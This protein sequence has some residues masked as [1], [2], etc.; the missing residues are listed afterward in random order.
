MPK[1]TRHAITILF[2]KISIHGCLLITLVLTLIFTADRNHQMTLLK[3]DETHLIKLVT[4]EYRLNFDIVC[5]DLIFLS[6]VVMYHYHTSGFD[7]RALNH[8]FIRLSASKKIY[9]SILLLNYKGAELSRVD[10]NDGN[11][12]IISKDHL[13]SM[14]DRPFFK[15]SIG[16]AMGDVSISSFQ[17]RRTDGRITEP[18][19][20]YLRFAT[21][22]FDRQGNR[23]GVIVLDYLV[24][25]LL[26]K[27]DQWGQDSAGRLMLINREGYYLKG[28]QPEHEWGFIFPKRSAH[29]IKNH[30]PMAWRQISASESGQFRTTNGLFSF[31]EILLLPDKIRSQRLSSVSIPS[32]SAVENGPWKLVS[33]VSNQDLTA[34]AMAILNHYF[35]IGF[36]LT[37]FWTTGA[38]WVAKAI[39]GGRSALGALKEN[40]MA[41][42][43][44]F[45]N[46]PNAYFSVRERDGRIIKHN[47]AAEKML[48]F[49]GEQL[50]GMRFTDLY[51]DTS[52]NLQPLR[53]IFNPEDQQRHYDNIEIQLICINGQ[54]KWA[55][56][57]IKPI[58]DPDGQIVER[59]MVLVD[60]TE[61]KKM[62]EDLAIFR[63]CI[64]LSSQGFGIADADTHIRYVNPALL[65]M[66]KEPHLDKVLEK[67]FT[68]YYNPEMRQRIDR[69][70]L[71]T[72]M[73]AGKW[74]GEMQLCAADGSIIP[75]WEH[76]FTIPDQ[77]GN[78]RYI[79]DIISDITV[80]KN[81]DV[82]I[83][84]SEARFRAIFDTVQAGIVIMEGDSKQVVAA[85]PAALR[86]LGLSQAQLIGRN[87]YTA[88]CTAA[89]DSCTIPELDEI[90]VNSETALI[91]SDGE[92]KHVLRTAT[93][94]TLKGK[95][96]L[97][98]SFVDISD[99]VV[100]RRAAE[101]ANEAKSLFLANMSHE[102][103][104]P[105]N[106][107]IGMTALLLASHLKPQQRQFAE[108]IRNSG[109]LLLGHVNDILDF[110]KIEA[111]KLEIESTDFDLQAM[112]GDL[113]DLLALKIQ[114]K[115]LEFICAVHPKVP[116]LLKGDPDKL[117]QI[118]LNLVGNA[119]K[120]TESGEINVQASV[121][122]QS[123]NEVTV[124]FSVSDTGV[125]IA[126][127]KQKAIFTSFTQADASISRKYGGTGLGLAISKR[128]CEAMG[129]EIKLKSQP[130]VG[131]EF[132]FTIHLVKQKGVASRQDLSADS[133]LH[134]Q[135]ILVVDD[136][137]SHREMLVL[138]LKHLHLN[139]VASD[140]G[141]AALASLTQAAK[142]KRPIQIVIL[143][144]QMPQMDGLMLGRAIKS[145]PL[146]QDTQLIMMTTM[147][148]IDQEDVLEEIGVSAYLVKP[149]KYDDLITSLRQVAGD[150][151]HLSESD[152]LERRRAGFRPGNKR[153]R[154]LIA[155]DDSTNQQVIRGILQ[156]LGFSDITVVD[157][158]AEAV[159]ATLK[160]A[161]DLILMDIQ[162]P[163]MDGLTATRHIRQAQK[164]G[165]PTPIVA[166]T[167]HALESDRQRCLA[168]GMV[169]YITKPIDVAALTA[170]LAR[171]LPKDI[172]TGTVTKE[173]AVP[174]H[175]NAMVH[176]TPK[177][178]SGSEDIFDQNAFQER[179]LGDQ[180]LARTI[181]AGFMQDMPL[182]ID[183][184]KFLVASNDLQ[185]AAIQAHKIKGAAG[186][187]GGN[188]FKKAAYQVEM[189]CKNNAVDTTQTLIPLLEEAFTQLKTAMKEMKL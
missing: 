54:L 154:L 116:T 7:L 67:S 55:N 121:A 73:E 92:E 123:E 56:L 112:M 63:R 39:I 8:H 36:T 46:A 126:E 94:L 99:L 61:K 88:H 81:A 29:T 66:I 1:T 137:A 145:D 83:K 100:A 91:D 188:L 11:P 141:P 182:Q 168:A 163:E 35:V 78:T 181:V 183:R 27:L 47:L 160:N 86:F 175:L 176:L 107:I 140:S 25:A 165:D 111:G 48:G 90:T 89:G 164:D 3:Q 155:E 130:S 118:L 30:L 114:T 34:Q 13:H 50:T 133:R 41:Y 103:R 144:R 101:T 10:Y 156:N 139:I 17:L 69:E 117:R 153:D 82:T 185:A 72:L 75:T 98:E 87:W 21:V 148:M 108:T 162:M 33:L 14:A 180:K 95:A 115:G 44:L 173:T 169:D 138:Q 124:K 68:S 26:D 24:K 186:N 23:I 59:R 158:G 110:S 40:E 71:P 106:G 119:L 147:A 2:L 161:Y 9:N 149:V 79:A 132:W 109:E 58:L 38:F 45:D 102:L 172:N 167:A 97:M 51:A 85:N 84:D 152:L 60:L 15:K 93:G 57:S 142:A 187:I 104:T 159:E 53:I 105:L 77:E 4:A 5:S 65:Q 178:E 52:D 129:A 22:L 127:E 18:I 6:H 179:L 62:T 80:R 76:Y 43:D 74:T 70:V 49:S 125:G 42:R 28:I 16:A 31:D 37:L 64:E 166:M 122:D 189:S 157:D 96:H 134:T 19:T 131:S 32:I 136:N 143:D 20:P 135:R 113:A 174:P 12:L 171:W 170:T 128:L 146:L 184:L 120:F 151:H 177:P 150:A